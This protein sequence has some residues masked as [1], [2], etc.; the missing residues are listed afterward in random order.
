MSVEA[1]SLSQAIGTGINFSPDPVNGGG[2]FGFFNG[3]GGFITALVFQTQI[4]AGLSDATIQGAFNCNAANPFFLGCAVA[5]APAN[6]LLTISFS[7]VNAEPPGE[8]PGDPEIGEH[9]GI[10]PLLPGCALTPDGAGCTVVGHFLVT[11]N[12]NFAVTG[13][14]GGWTPGKNPAL[15]DV[16]P[17]FTP[18]EIDSTATPEPSTLVLLA[19][20]LLVLAGLSGRRVRRYRLQQ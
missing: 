10:P 18:I 13:N 14:V 11:L 7:G 17:T 16:L 5:Y 6:G 9:E 15:F 2:L 8:P 4:V 1:G 12:D 19:T 20:A 3:T